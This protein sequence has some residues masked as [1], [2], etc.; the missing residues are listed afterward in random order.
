[1]SRGTNHCTQE[2]TTDTRREQKAQVGPHRASAITRS[3]GLR[4]RERRFESCRG[5]HPLTSRY[6]FKRLSQC[7]IWRPRGMSSGTNS[8][9]IA[10]HVD[11]DRLAL[12]PAAGPAVAFS[13]VVG[14]NAVALGWSSRR[15]R[16]ALVSVPSPAGHNQYPTSRNP[17]ASRRPRESFSGQRRGP[18]RLGAAVTAVVGGAV[19]EP[20]GRP[21]QRSAAAPVAGAGSLDRLEVVGVRRL[22]RGGAHPPD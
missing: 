19:V 20:V 14:S 1:M 13:Q 18:C 8:S 21:G 4:R 17:E 5:H 3:T 12:L 6:Y 9:H 22:A 15:S 10:L 2:V 7:P 11:L 16:C